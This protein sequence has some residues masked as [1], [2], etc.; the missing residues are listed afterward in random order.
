MSIKRGTTPLLHKSL[1][2]TPTAQLLFKESKGNNCILEFLKKKSNSSLELKVQSCSNYHMYQL[3]IQIEI[4]LEHKHFR[5]LDICCNF[6]YFL[7]AGIYA[8]VV[9]KGE[10]DMNL[11]ELATE[12]RGMVKTRISSF[13][14]PD[15]ILVMIYMSKSNEN[16]RFWNHL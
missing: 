7:F 3:L 14:Q 10:S 6:I 16:Y 8:F 15:K 4:F 5:N 11:D 1:K 12:L 2:H 9:L 13:A